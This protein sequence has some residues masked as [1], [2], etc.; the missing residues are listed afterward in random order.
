MAIIQW[1][2]F[3]WMQDPFESAFDELENVM[4]AKLT[5][6][7][8]AVDIYQTEK[9]VIVEMPLAGVDPEKVEIAIE[10]NTLTVKGS[11]EKKTEVDEKNYYRK[12]VRSGSFYRA[13][14]LPVPVVKDKA[15]AVSENGI[16][17]ISVPKA[18]EVKAK[19]VPV[20][21]KI[22]KK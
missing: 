5:T 11:S 10:D 4:P 21:V 15:S 18:P 8:P 16:L 14:S 3:G 1:R 20:K 6:F 13:V 19:T 7:T 12:E 22:A 9:D 17:K 2:P